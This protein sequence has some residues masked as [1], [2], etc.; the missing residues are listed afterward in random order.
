MF[1]EFAVT[2]S[3]AIGVSLVI[4]LTTTP[5]MCAYLL[6][7]NDPAKRSKLYRAS[8]RVFDW[9][10]AAYDHSLRWVLRHQFFTMLVT[11]ATVAL[12]VYLYI[13]VPKGFFP[14]QDTGRLVGSLQADQNI[15]FQSMRQLT[16][17]FSKIVGEDPAVA[18]VVASTGGGGGGGGGSVNTARMFCSLKP[19]AER[20]L[21]ADKVIARLRK[22]L[23]SEPGATLLLQ[24]TQDLRIGGK[25]SSA[26][27]QY[28]LRSDS[29]KDINTW[30]PRLLEK[31]R[32]IP[33][34]VDA[35]SDQLN[36]GNQ[37]ALNV[38]RVRAAQLGI[39]QQAIDDA[40]YDAFGQRQ[41]STM[42]TTLNQFRV[43]MEV[44]PEFRENPD[45]LQY[46]TCGAKNNT[47]IPLSAIAAEKENTTPLS[48]NHYGQF[49]CV[50]FS[51]NLQPAHR[52]AKSSR[53]SNRRSST[54]A[55]RKICKEVSK[56]RPKRFAIRSRTNR[57]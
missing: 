53:T 31:L 48:V 15:S 4:S 14:Q 22:R 38:D 18:S 40:L 11:L 17:R 41:V 26:Q 27:Y 1:R 28:T 42:Y 56:A 7:K 9:I 29:L 52:W 8:E 35:N 16:E 44:E 13:E 6:K 51:F 45:S 55:C 25:S 24:S 3:V 33:G 5:M 43:V 10:L 20:Q 23:A 54:W 12:T 39:T 37:V 47:Q 46:C 30:T 19:I 49:P 32:A 2:L 21:S 36:R 50:T 57:C 34:V